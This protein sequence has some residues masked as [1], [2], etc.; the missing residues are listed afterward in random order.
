MKGSRYTFK[1]Q[2]LRDI[3]AVKWIP[4]DEDSIVG[5][6]QI[7]HGMA[8]HIERYEDF[9]L[10]LNSKGFVVAGHDHRGHGKSIENESG[11]G[12]FSGKDGWEK[13]VNDARKVTSHIRDQHGDI[14]LFIV[15]HSMGSFI[16]R[17][18]ISRWGDDVTGVILSGTGNQ[19]PALMNVL[20]VLTRLEI[21]F[22]GMHHRSSFFDRLSFGTF[23]KPFE[24]GAP[25]PFEWLS[26][27]REQV[28]RYVADPLCGFICTS[29]F[30]RDLSKGLKRVC[31][32]GIYKEVPEDLS[33]LLYSGDEDPVG[34]V[35]GSFVMEVY[36][37][38]KAAGLSDVEMILNPGGRH[39]NLNETNRREVYDTF[40]KWLIEHLPALEEKR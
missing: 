13:V 38:Y 9:A 15:S 34:G 11:T 27:D 3:S 36:N 33:I 6:V 5:A 30:F 16:A 23:N 28:D 37:N 20:G 7:F 35:K 26:R 31:S 2:D 19:S 12:F 22:R 39:E 10:F 32:P 21:L 1:S 14:P 25:T 4:E 17:D 24:P 29:S 8:E 18:Y 40:C